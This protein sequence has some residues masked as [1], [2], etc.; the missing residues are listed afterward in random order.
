MYKA[1]GSASDVPI[2]VA[3]GA[4]DEIISIRKSRE[5]DPLGSEDE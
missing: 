5:D 2:H 4:G 3:D 1:L